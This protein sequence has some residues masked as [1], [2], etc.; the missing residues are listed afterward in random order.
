M[1]RTVAGGL[2]LFI[3]ML[4]PRFAA[5][6]AT[7]RLS[8]SV[9]DGG[10][11]PLPDAVLKLSRPGATVVYA[12]AHSSSSGAFSFPLIPPGSYDL[13]VEAAGYSPQ[14]V[15]G[16]RIDASAETNVPPILLVRTPVAPVAAADRARSDP[17]ETAYSV[18][19][20]MLRR[21]PTAGR[22]AFDLLGLLPGVTVNGRSGLA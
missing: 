17:A 10:D 3:Y 13:N 14:T 11:K 4:T 2:L 22:D 7:G 5:A 16:L 19:G 21:L 20:Q 15:T 8:G 9:R 1:P 6:Q 18:D 12:W